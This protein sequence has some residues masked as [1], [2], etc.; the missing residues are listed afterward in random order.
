MAPATEAAA[1][2][3][4]G[5]PATGYFTHPAFLK[6]RTGEGHPE[7]PARLTTI[8]T[9][10]KQKGLWERLAPAARAFKPQLIMVSAGYDS[11]ADDPLGGLGLETEDF[12]RLTRMVLDLADELCQGRVVIA[13]EGGYDLNALGASA[14]ATIAELDA[15]SRQAR[16]P[17][18][19]PVGAPSHKD[20]HRLIQQ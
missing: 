12:G 15:R 18:A 1:G 16:P 11:H 14:A 7:R 9:A 6:H 13:L 4:S 3:A 17:L 2:H 5:T 19:S 8:E 10:L 20:N